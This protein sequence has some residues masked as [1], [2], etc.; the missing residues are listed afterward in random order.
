MLHAGRWTP[1]SRRHLNDEALPVHIRVIHAETHG[2]YGWPRV[3]R[4]LLARGDSRQP[5]AVRRKLVRRP[6]SA[7]QPIARYGV[8]VPGARSLRAA[9][10][11]SFSRLTSAESALLARVRRCPAKPCRATQALRSSMTKRSVGAA[12]RGSRQA[13]R[14]AIRPA[15]GLGAA[16]MA[17]R[18]QTLHLKRMP[19]PRECC[20]RPR[21]GRHGEAGELVL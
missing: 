6:T 14:P 9:Y 16:S 3:W 21:H 4:E 18:G 17:R 19:F 1:P 7:G 20:A 12:I 8:R 13:R 2:A 11:R 10:R 15:A 5:G